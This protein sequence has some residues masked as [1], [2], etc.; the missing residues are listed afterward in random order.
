MADYSE[1]FIYATTHDFKSNIAKYLRL[2]EKGA[3]DAVFI[4]RYDKKIAFVVPFEKRV[5]EAKAELKSRQKL[6]EQKRRDEQG[7][8]VF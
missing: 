4:K 7:Q 3:Y 2:L 8:D 6:T 1:R 5:N